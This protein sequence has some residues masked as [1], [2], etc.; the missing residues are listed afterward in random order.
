MSGRHLKWV[1]VNK[2]FAKGSLLL[3]SLTTSSRWFQQVVQKSGSS[4][5]IGILNL[6]LKQKVFV[7]RQGSVLSDKALTV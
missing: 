5:N 3:L 2:C 1:G 4:D 6:D 7:I